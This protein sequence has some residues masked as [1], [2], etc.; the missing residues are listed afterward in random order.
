M[1][2][3]YEQ[4]A[5]LTT[6]L[7][8]DIFNFPLTKDELW[9][10][11]LTE[12]PVTKKAFEEALQV[13]SSSK[14]S[15]R[16]IQREGFYA[17]AGRQS[18][19][20]KRITYL[21]EIERKLQLAKQAA[22]ALS[23]IP[24]IQC[25][26]ISGGLSVGNVT[27]KDDIDFFIITKKNTL[28][29]T[30][31]WILLLLEWLGLRRKWNVS[32]AANKICVNLLIDETQ[33]TWPRDK[34]DIYTAHEIVQLKPL[35]EREYMYQRFLKSNTW[36]TYYMSQW[37]SDNQRISSHTNRWMN[38]FGV[39]IMNPFSERVFRMFQQL[40]MKKHKTTERVEKSLLAFHP[41]DY[42]IETLTQLRSKCKQFGL[43]TNF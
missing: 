10:Y 19:I 27:D 2:F 31:L 32:D 18:L 21:P 3:N 13:L 14:A 41:K 43:L 24:S 26:G 37:R 35:F 12:K 29:S 4:Q 25:I 36:T 6:L 33:L 30:R 39:T 5:I 1:V 42:R 40:Y 15:R 9:Q 11:L 38:V 28:F 34:Q 16:I 22:A 23:V 20:T 8:S 17:L 7:Y